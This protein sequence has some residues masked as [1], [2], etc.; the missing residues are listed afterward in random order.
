MPCDDALPIAILSTRKDGI[1]KVRQRLQ[2]PTFDPLAMAEVERKVRDILSAVRQ[3]GDEALVAIEQ[4]VGWKGCTK[5]RLKVSDDELEEAE[6]QVPAKVLDAL[7]L[8]HQRLESFHRRQ[9]PSSWFVNDE[10]ALLGQLVQPMERVGIYVPGGLAAYPSTV[11]HVAVPAKVAGV[12]ELYLATPPDEQGRI[13]PVV[14]AAARLCG[15]QAV[16]RV[17]GAHAIAAFAF[18]TETIPKVDKIAGPGGVYPVV[19]KRLLYGVVGI[20]LLPGPSEVAVIADD[21]APAE[22]VAMELLAQAEHGPDSVAV[23]LTPSAKLLDDVAEIL[24]R[25]LLRSPRRRYLEPALR[26]HGALV[27]TRH[28]QE[29]IELANDGAFEHVALMVADPMAWVGKLKHAGAI[30]LGATTSV[31]FGDYLAGPSHV[32]PTGGTARFASGLSVHDFLRRTSLVMLSSE[33]ASQL[34]EAAA[35][36]ADAEGLPA[37]AKALRARKKRQA[38]GD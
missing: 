19:A 26:H 9:L 22:W 29:A 23:L 5:E 30:F 14:L 18:G 32:L 10:G 4:Q 35:T 7:R 3:Q 15:V 2:R 8:A 11:L 20:D 21:T 25:R 36:L 34:A 17:G 31:A 13:P 27:L 6:R 37:H 1:E 38:T 16:F 33:Q 28:L 24:R 12:K